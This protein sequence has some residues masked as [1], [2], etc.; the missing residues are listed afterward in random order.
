[1]VLKRIRRSLWLVWAIATLWLAP[2]SAQATM[3]RLVTVLG[4]IDIELYDEGA[5]LTV[6]NFLGYV[7]SGAYDSSFFHRSEPGFVI[8]GGGYRWI[9]QIST[10]Q[11]IPAGPPVTNEFSP[12]RSNVRGTV[13]MAKLG[14]QPNSATTE[15]FVNLANNASNLDNQNGGFT[16][17]G[18]VTAP[19]M[20]IVDRIAA[21]RRVNYVGSPFSN[22]P[23]LNVPPSGPLLRAHYAMV[24][25]AMVLPA[26]VAQSDSDRVFNYL[27]AVYPQYAAPASP[28]SDTA[29]GYY[30]RYY[31]ATNAYLGT[32]DGQ[33]YYLVPSISNEIQRLG[34]LAEW[35]AIAKAAGY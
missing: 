21:L 11:R 28:A 23:V 26:I 31:S 24:N 15:W 29:I 33:V 10:F 6:A 27:E 32:A 22:L 19:G 12:T 18:K 30:Y 9:D 1:M 25:T 13:A 17:F 14:G 35:L 4:P 2:L 20:A 34:S 3:V 16:V 7:G 5:P 8:Q